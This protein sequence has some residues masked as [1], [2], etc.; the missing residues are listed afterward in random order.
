MVTPLASMSGE[1]LNIPQGLTWVLLCSPG[2]WV[3]SCSQGGG[4]V[5]GKSRR[6]SR[7]EGCD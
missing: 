6:A 7:L 3:V 4:V 1:A 5:L 2:G